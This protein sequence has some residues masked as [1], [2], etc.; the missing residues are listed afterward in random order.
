METISTVSLPLRNRALVLL[1]LGGFVA[2]LVEAFAIG[3]LVRSINKSLWENALVFFLISVICLPLFVFCLREFKK[4]HFRNSILLSIC[5]LFS[6][7]LPVLIK[8]SVYV[9]GNPCIGI[10]IPLGSERVAYVPKEGTESNDF[11]GPPVYHA[12][13]IGPML[14][15]Y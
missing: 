15:V 7:L 8:P 1:C 6:L 5:L 3:H 4:K 13:C 14:D 11:L 9:F 12:V 2:L 10:N